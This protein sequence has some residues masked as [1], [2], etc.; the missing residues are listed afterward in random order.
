[1]ATSDYIAIGI[2]LLCVLMSML[3]ALKW[4]LRF[5]AGAIV[6]M[7]VLGCIGLLSEN[8]EF[9]RVSRGL[10][11]D[12]IIVPCMRSQIHM[13]G[14]YIGGEDDVS[15]PEAALAVNK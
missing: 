10:F 11:R 4:M 15:H 13:V 14:K 2:L 5:F 1:M 7:I 9:D 3:G 12:G 8:P 6:G